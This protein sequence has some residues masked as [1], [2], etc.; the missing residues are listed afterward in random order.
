MAAGFQKNLPWGS[1]LDV[2][3]HPTLE[4][5]NEMANWHSP[6]CFTQELNDQCEKD[7]HSTF[8]KGHCVSYKEYCMDHGYSNPILGNSSFVM[9]DENNSLSEVIQK[10]AI[11]PPEDYFSGFVLGFTIPGSGGET[12][13]WENYGSLSW[14]LCLC[15]LLSWLL[16]Y[17]S[18]IKGL[19]SYGKVVY[20]TTAA[21]YVVLT[22]FLAYTVTLPGAKNG[23]DFFLTPDWS[24]L[25]VSSTIVIITKPL[26]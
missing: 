1:C 23:I 8:Y 6:D 7:Y 3:T 9:C 11:Y 5:S 21:P 24:K 2:D 22:A 18:M 17:G 4:S 25:S 13:S 15:F 12:H 14:E 20:I 16:I 19:Q 10:N 26:G